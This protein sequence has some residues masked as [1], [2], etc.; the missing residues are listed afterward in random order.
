MARFAMTPARPPRPAPIAP[1][2]TVNKAGGEA[3][4]VT[5]PSQRMLTMLGS[6]FWNEPTYYGD[7]PGAERVAGLSDEATLV[8]ETARE[9]AR[10]SSPRDLLALALWARTDMNI[11]TT[12]QVLLAVA[13][14]EPATKGFVRQYCPR[15]IQRADEIR[16]VFAAHLA[17][18]AKGVGKNSGNQ[19]LPNS[20]KRGLADAFG[21]FSEA[22]LM[23]YDSEVRPT[24]KDVLRMIDRGKDYALPQAIYRYFMTGEITDPAAMPTI[25]LRRSL[26]KKTELDGEARTLIRESH[27]TWEVVLS[28]FGRKKEVWQAV[29]PEI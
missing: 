6:S 29:L 11:R 18:Y 8:I 14:N 23:K 13:A 17:L 2:V 3:F 20:L 24:F 5:H 27:A 22:Q 9:I 10:S 25:A 4:T 12:P 15:V 16:Q 28:Q 26:A 21:R 19:K 7:T 1:L